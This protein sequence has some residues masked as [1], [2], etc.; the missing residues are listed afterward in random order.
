MLIVERVLA[1]A[2]AGLGADHVFLA[3]GGSSNDPVRTAARL[4]RDRAR[5]VDIG[6]CG[7]WTERRN[8]SCF[9]DLLARGRLSLEPLVSGAFPVADAVDVY[10]R[11]S[12]GELA[13]VGFLFTYPDPPE[14]SPSKGTPPVPAVGAAVP[15]ASRPSGPRRS[16]LR[17]AFLGAGNYASSMLLP[18]LKEAEGV[19]LARV[20]TTTSL[21]AA[22]A[23]WRSHWRSLPPSSTGCRPWW[24]PPATIA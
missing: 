17:L 14:T 1:Q 5:V 11:L 16:A 22:N 4:A 7:L 10:G 12:A 24:P 9:L 18:H 6:K 19:E 13:G 23:Q 2:T 3:A 15:P 20:A 8:L 21:S